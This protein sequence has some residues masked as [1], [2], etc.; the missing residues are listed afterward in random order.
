MVMIK[1][2]LRGIA[3]CIIFMVMF[4]S[5]TILAQEPHLFASISNPRM[6]LYKNISSE[7]LRFE[8]N[9]IVN[10]KN[11]FPVD[12]EITPKGT[13]VDKVIIKESEFTLQP[14]ERKEVLYDIIIEDSG[15]YGGDIQVTFTGGENKNKLSLLQRVVVHVSDEN[16]D[17]SLNLI[18][19]SITSILILLV[20]LLTLIKKRKIKRKKKKK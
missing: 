17:S 14:G 1:K 3:Y 13:W 9:V 6:V 12:I 8:N 20:I 11:E 15:E 10:N 5:T 19:I 2:G 16:G 18:L 7:P 4:C